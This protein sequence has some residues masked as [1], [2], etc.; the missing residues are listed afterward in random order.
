MGTAAFVWCTLFFFVNNIEA[1]SQRAAVEFF[2]GHAGE[3]C[4]LLTKGYKSYVPEFYGRM[5][6][7]QPPEDVLLH[8]PIDRPVYLSC[9]ITAIEEVRALGTFTELYRRNGFVFLHR[10]P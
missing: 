4:W 8:G 10:T 6:E 9:K 5:A 7:A 2:E 3:R 1:Y